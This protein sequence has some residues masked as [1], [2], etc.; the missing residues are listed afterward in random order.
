GVRQRA[1]PEGHRQAR[2][3]AARPPSLCRSRIR[4]PALS[5][6]PRLPLALQACGGRLP[7]RGEAPDEQRDGADLPRL[8][9][10]SGLSGHAQG[11]RAPWRPGHRRLETRDERLTPAVA[12]VHLPPPAHLH[13][14]RA[15]QPGS[16]RGAVRRDHRL[17]AGARR[18]DLRFRRDSGAGARLRV[19]PHRLLPL[20]RR[21]RVMTAAELLARL[22]P[23]GVKVWSEAG[24][25]AIRA[26]KGVLNDELRTALS[27][28]KDELL[29]ILAAQGSD[30][31]ALPR[32]R[33]A[34]HERHEPFPLTELQQ[35]YWVGRG[36]IVELS[37]AIHSYTE[38][39]D[40][41]DLERLSA[42]WQTLIDRHEMLRAVAL[43]TGEQKI[44]TSVPRYRIETED[45]RGET[46]ERAA[47]RLSAARERMSH[48]IFPLEQW[49]PFELR[50]FL[51]AERKVRVCI[52][53][54]CTFLDAWSL[55]IL[56]RELVQAYRR[57]DQP[58]EPRTLEL[59]YRDYVLGL[60]GLAETNSYQKSIAYWRDQIATL[61]PPPPPP[62]AVDAAALGRPRY[63]RWVERIDPASW[64]RLKSQAQRRGITPPGLLL[65]AWAEVL[66]RWSRT[67][68]FTLNVPLYNRLPLHPQIHD[69]VG[70]FSSFTLVEVD[71][72][73]RRSFEQRARAIQQR[74][75]DAL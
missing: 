36:G 49:P 57:P 44:L 54:D 39:E 34:P 27:T 7:R 56:F 16:G 12:G 71:P 73:G 50:A 4:R 19:R 5:N 11:A 46:P 67:P 21:E 18:A 60:A 20:L 40:D 68:R 58:L 55:Q 74:L 25:L 8:R 26:P 61:P 2:H 48:Q 45:L 29:A 30:D 52:S 6:G 69:V 53:I 14:L 47:A 51:L 59:S 42:A 3:H 1:K 64:E 31:D 28:G 65:A 13:P 10:R 43:P 33:I 22:L 41:I 70:T 15:L 9:R 35:A 38:I 63:R 72:R 75:W 17:D 66:G 23:L 32:L 62:L 37:T 24:Q